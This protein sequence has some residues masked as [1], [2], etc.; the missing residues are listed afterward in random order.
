MPSS[1]R[2]RPRSFV[3]LGGWPA[4]E[5]NEGSALCRRGA[6]LGPDAPGDRE[7][8]SAAEGR[9]RRLAAAP[10]GPAV[11]KRKVL[12][13]EHPVLAEAMTNLAERLAGQ[14]RL[15]EAEPLYRDALGVWQ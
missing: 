15:A 1:A 8:G 2:C 4:L 5:G 10:P 12:G 13:N 6:L 7:A 11:L 14:Q 9:E 3:R